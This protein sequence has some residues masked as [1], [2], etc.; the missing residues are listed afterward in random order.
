MAQSLFIDIGEKELCTYLFDFKNGRYE[1]K[2][3]RKY[4]LHDKY[5]FSFPSIEGDIDNAYLSLPVS[6]LNFRVIDLPFSDKDRIREVLP[7][8]LDGM[9]LG[10]SDKVV[11][12]D[13]IV[14]KSNNTYQ[15]LAVYIEKK[16]IGEILE[17]LK[18]L[19]IDPVSITCLELKS[20]V[21]DFDSAKLFSPIV[22]GDKD[23]VAMAVEEMKAPVINLRRD[24]FSFTRDIQKTKKSLRITA[25][26]AVIIALILSAGIL[27][28]LVSARY[29]IASLKNDMRKKYQEMFPGEKNIMNELLQ[30]KSHLKELKGKED[31]LVGINPLNVLSRLSQ[32]ERHGVVFHEI[33]AGKD[34]I[35]MKGE[36]LS[37]SDIQELK[38][39]LE[40]LLNEV[41]LSD[42]KA[43]AQGRMLFTITGK[44][45]KV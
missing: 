18:S 3:D 23:R 12:D 13:I 37:L 31:L 6:S 30:V 44:E 8:E 40:S 19:N 35:I 21:K 24:E 10:G 20:A 11:F 28:K 41:T 43:S 17:K 4:P 7:F 39:R 42:S 29:E 22:T 14:G 5:D 32:L 34:Q 38:G 15:V 9:I 36:A 26:L 33:T 2:D 25:L 27:V 45:K 16:I 1:L